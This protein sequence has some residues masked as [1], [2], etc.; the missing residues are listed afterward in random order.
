S[1]YRPIDDRMVQLKS[2]YE[3][4][5][6]RTEVRSRYADSHLGHVFNDGPSP[7]GMRYCINSAALKFIKKEDLHALGY[8]ELAALFEDRTE[9]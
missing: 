3:L 1:F 8:G 2:D 6:P 7:T 9:K 5:V 4:W